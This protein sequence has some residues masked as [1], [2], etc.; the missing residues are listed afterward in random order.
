MGIDNQISTESNEVQMKKK[1]QR[2]K[3]TKSCFLEKINETDK[4]LGKF[5]KKRERGSK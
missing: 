4:S 5:K 1:V 2:M 3:K